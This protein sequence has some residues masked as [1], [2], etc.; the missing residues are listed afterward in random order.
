VS[1]AAIEGVR[2]FH[3]RSVRRNQSGAKP[4]LHTSRRS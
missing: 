2:F 4:R 1:I 3:V